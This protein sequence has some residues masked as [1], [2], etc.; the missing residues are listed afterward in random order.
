MHA[1]SLPAQR[2]FAETAR[3][4]AWWVQSAVTFAVFSAF[5]IYSTWAA[6]AAADFE[7][8]PY[9]SPMYS[10]LL[11]G[12]SAHS[13]FGGAF[14]PDFWPGFLRYSPAALILWAPVGFRIT[15][16]YYRGAYY[17][18]FWADPPGCAVGEPRK[19]Y[20]GEQKFPLL[21]QNIH[22]YFLYVAIIF[23]G[24]LSYDAWVAMWFPADGSTTLRAGA[25]TEFGIGVGTLILIAN[26][27]F[28]GL[29]TFGCHSLRHLVGG[30]LDVMSGRPVRKTA[31]ACVSCLNRWHMK[32]AWI[33]LI[34][35]G[36]SDLYVR[37]CSMGIW[38]DVRL[39]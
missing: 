22:R 36:F 24:I 30:L 23:I 38:T 39:L 26:A 7:Y 13:W 28:L 11:F 16:Y 20:R 18:A 12:P 29:Y 19:A 6:Y 17:K 8:G 9:L 1:S 33:S 15:C 10:P 37:M 35:V 14:Q 34:W 2:R 3:R 32:W 4:D 25:A 5:V 27:V 21:I 31:Y